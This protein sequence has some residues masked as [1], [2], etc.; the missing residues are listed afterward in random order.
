MLI[1]KYQGFFIFIFILANLNYTHLSGRGS[2][3]AFKVFDLHPAK[4]LCSCNLLS[5]G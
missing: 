3:A 2:A 5:M 4:S 1:L